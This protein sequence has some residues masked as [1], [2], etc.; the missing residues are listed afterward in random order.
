M[1]NLL[2]LIGGNAVSHLITF[3][4]APLIT[5]LYSPGELGDLSMM[6]AA[7]AILNV[8]STMKF[9]LAIPLAKNDK[10]T[11][12]LLVICFAALLATSIIYLLLTVGFALLS[13]M[14]TLG[15]AILLL[16]IML[17][18]EG[19]FTIAV[20][21]GLRLKKYKHISLIKVNKSIIMNSGQ[22]GFGLISSSSFSIIMGDLIGRLLGANRML[23]DMKNYIASQK[24][25]ISK[26]SM[27]KVAVEFKNYPLVSSFSSFLNSIALQ[28]FPLMLGVLYGSASLGIYALSQRILIGPLSL[29]SQAF[30]QIFLSEAAENIRNGSTRGLV[31]LFMYTVGVLLLFVSIILSIFLLWGEEIINLV[32]GSEWTGSHDIIKYMSIMILFQ[33]VAS[34]LS[35]TLNLLSKQ[36]FQFYWDLARFII[37]SSFLLVIYLFGVGF[38]LTI[39]IYSVLMAIMYITLFG[40]IIKQLFSLEKRSIC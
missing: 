11:A 32:F 16:P 36:A 25:F 17:L 29:V 14:N 19:L 6:I 40:I 21:Y 8:F 20:H 22:I 31:K 27:K 24:A 26:N 33:F 18:G 9:E 28:A 30:S 34:P 13:P 2:N 10:D 4:A 7:L 15:M 5:R 1:K 39:F 3:A 37:I 23:M 35:Q 38:Y 12:N